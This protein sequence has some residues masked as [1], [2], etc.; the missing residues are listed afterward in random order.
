MTG[1][2]NL[3]VLSVIGNLRLGG[4]ETYLARIAPEMSAHR[5]DMEICALER[6]GPLL[7]PL[8]QAGIR[9]HGTPYPGRTDHSNTLTLFR[10]VDS[11][12]RTVRAGRFDVVHTYLFW[13]DVLGVAGARLAGCRRIIVGRRALHS[14]GHS[15]SNFFHGLEQ[16][17][18]IFANEM[19]ANSRAVLLDAEAHEPF[20]PARRTVIHNGIDVESYKAARPSLEGP[21]RVVTVGALA[22]RKGQEYAVEAMAS[23]ARAGVDSSLELV[24]SGPDEAMLR[25]LVAARGL[26]RSVTFAGEQ[27]DPRPYLSRADLFLLPSRQEGFSNALLEAM[28]SGLPVVATDVGGNSEAVVDGEGGRVVPPEQPDAIAQAIAAFA[29][30]RTKLSEMGSSNRQ[31]VSD[32]FSLEASARRL[33]DWYRSG[34]LARPKEGR[35]N[36]GE[37]LPPRR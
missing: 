17:S 19:V 15:R 23:L 6:E 8:E 10:T 36:P 31:R 22:P 1:E 13:S 11:I 28:A 29:R 34:P 25:N 37:D 2:R 30:D 4:T 9:V 3:R 35:P 20:L 26:E 18:N 32:L 33:A 27:V 21:L 16:L 24:G 5:V 14:W 12:R 7:L